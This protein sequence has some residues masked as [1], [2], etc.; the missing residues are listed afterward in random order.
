MNLFKKVL[1]TVTDKSCNFFFSI[2]RLSIN[3]RN[4]RLKTFEKC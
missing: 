4:N 2:Q 1:V 3:E